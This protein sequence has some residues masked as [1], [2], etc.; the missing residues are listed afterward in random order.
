MWRQNKVSESGRGQGLHGL[1]LWEAQA[2]TP[3]G[4]KGGQ[5]RSGQGTA[6][7][8][9][10]LTGLRRPAP[11]QCWARPPAWPGCAASR[12]RSSGPQT[13]KPHPTTSRP[14]G[15]DASLG[16]PASAT[17]EP[18]GG[19]GPATLRAPPPG[20]RGSHRARPAPRGGGR[21]LRDRL[22]CK[23][24]G[25]EL[26]PLP[27]VPE[28]QPPPHRGAAPAGPRPAPAHWLRAPGAASG[29]SR[30]RPP[31]V[32]CLSLARRPPAFVCPHIAFT[33]RA[34]P[35]PGANL[36]C[37]SWRRDDGGDRIADLG[38]R[39][40]QPAIDTQGSSGADLQKWPGPLL[41]R[42]TR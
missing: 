31:S 21:S 11:R 38:R 3:P 29:R 28:R 34:L 8:A 2:E 39:R 22:G 4:M 24:R 23:W 37:R 18:P 7:P 26:P 33:A 25:R 10:P 20:R 32:L 14:Y 16:I 13:P 1:C 5:Q 19:V 9:R 12:A 41:P 42:F 27:V 35:P 17:R 36:L 40:V 6:R 15:T 30:R